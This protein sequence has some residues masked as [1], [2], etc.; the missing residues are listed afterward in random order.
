MA[1]F[2]RQKQCYY[3]D[4]IIPRADPTTF[5]VFE[6]PY[7]KDKNNVYYVFCDESDCYDTTVL[8]NSDPLT[9]EVLEWPY[10]KDKNNVYYEDEIIPRA[11]PTTFEVFEWPYSKDKNNVYYVFCDESDCYDTTVLENRSEE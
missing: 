10:S 9:F 6:W 7:S 3:E 8:E 5:E 2:Q 11:D 4:E 1:L